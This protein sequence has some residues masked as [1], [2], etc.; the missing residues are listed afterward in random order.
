MWLKWLDG[1]THEPVLSKVG[2]SAT[3][4][5]GLYSSGTDNSICAVSSNGTAQL[6]AQLLSGVQDVVVLDL[7]QVVRVSVTIFSQSLSCFKL[8]K[9]MLNLLA[10][11]TSTAAIEGPLTAACI[12]LAEHSLNPISLKCPASQ[13]FSKVLTVYPCISVLVQSSHF[14]RLIFFS[15]LSSSLTAVTADLTYHSFLRLHPMYPHLR[16]L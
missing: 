14:E 4:G 3:V 9:G 13:A 12:V 5:T 2:V 16:R 6:R 7:K 10:D 15:P 8:D 11:S 1:V